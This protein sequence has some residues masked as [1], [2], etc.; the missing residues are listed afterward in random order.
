MQSSL[1]AHEKMTMSLAYIRCEMGLQP[2]ES[3]NPARRLVTWAFCN[4]WDRISEQRMNKYGERG[5]P[6]RIPVFAENHPETEPL[7][8]KANSGLVVWPRKSN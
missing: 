7:I 5:Q 2:G 4:M 3:F 1:T 8:M 6:C